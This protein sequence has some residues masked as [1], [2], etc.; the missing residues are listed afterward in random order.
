MISVFIYLFIYYNFFHVPK[1]SGMSRNVPCSRFETATVLCAC[2]TSWH[3][4]V[5][6]GEPVWS[7]SKV[8]HSS[9]EEDMDLATLFDNLRKEVSCSVCSAIF[10]DPKQLSCLHSFCLNCLKRWYAACGIRDAIECP[11][12]K[13][14]SPVPASGY[15]NDLPTSFYLNRLIELL[16]IK[17]ARRLQWNVETATDAFRF[18]IVSSA[19][20]FIA[21]FA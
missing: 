2:V 1:C 15:L 20:Y 16:H 13:T 11:Q 18:R 17:G 9:L 3:F 21:N 14:L 5:W 7:V 10:S 19:E 8:D 12:C 6:C 4:I